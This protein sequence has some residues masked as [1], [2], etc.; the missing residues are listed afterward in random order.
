MGLDSV[1]LV[2]RVE[3]EF[4]IEI[5]DAD[6][7][8]LTTVGH[9]HAYVVEALRHQGR[10][11]S[12]DSVYDQLRDIICHQLGVKEAEVVPSARFVDDLGVD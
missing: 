5:P 12:A 11:E 4:A 9:L 7:P 2:I 6:A 3:K 1:E 8:A 10:I